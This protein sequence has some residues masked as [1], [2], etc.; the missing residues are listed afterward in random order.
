MRRDS[1]AV[2]AALIV[3][4]LLMISPALFAFRS[5]VIGDGGDNYH[6]LGFQYLA[7]RLFYSGQFPF[8]WTDYWR[9][10][11]GIQFQSAFDSSLFAIVGIPLYAAVHDPVAV[12]NLSVLI[13]IFLNL[14]L[15]YI[16]F[17]TWFEKETAFVGAIIYGLSFYTLAK[18]GGHVNLL[19]TA[20]FPM[21]FS[22]AY[23]IYRD[24]SA[25]NVV[26]LAGASLYLA[27]S[28][29]QYPLLL[30]GSLPFTVAVLLFFI[31]DGLTR[32]GR[33]L[34]SNKLALLAAII[35]MTVGLSLFHGHKLLELWRGEVIMPSEEI[36]FV[37][38][39]NFVVPNAYV[40]TISSVV[41]NATRSWIEYSV[42]LGYLEIVLFAVAAVR[43]KSSPVK[44][45]LI[46]ATAVFFVL[47]AGWWPY[48]YLFK[49]MPYRGIIEPGRFYTLLYLWITL[50]ILLYLRQLR[51]RRV[52]LLI[53]LA[54]LAE[55]LPR[56]FYLSP[57]HRDPALI[58]A[59][60]ARDTRAVFDFPPYYSW[61]KGQFYDLYSVH[62]QRPIVT[63]Y[64]HWSA[65]RP[66]ENDLLLQLGEFRC[67][68]EPAQVMREYD[69]DKAARKREQIIEWM[70][71]HAVR[72]V[73]VHKDLFGSN[74]QCGAAS[75]YVQS[76]FEDEHK[77]EVLME[78]ARKRVLWLR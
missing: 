20:G 75:L 9:Y 63:G 28:S 16:S 50:L 76:L 35:G 61:W 11:D 47:S 31:P 19:E 77:W 70:Q 44:H 57:T 55:R 34:W 59:V 49:V 43:L 68:Y 42:F 41:H 52:I 12:Y 29:L 56:R 73:V 8:G 54:I 7:Q 14:S 10:P 69:P 51:S 48:R 53:A 26:L 37:P 25:A 4:P 58:A 72:T 71:K 78:D 24:G 32:F 23:R 62:Y 21:F 66:G 39:I 30:L 74:E 45:S 27:F 36:V 6:F 38:L 40:P 13:L 33:M 67:Y 1:A 2:G 15:A 65:D 17:R 3:L 60:A 46:F 64:F 5:A 18:V 22:A